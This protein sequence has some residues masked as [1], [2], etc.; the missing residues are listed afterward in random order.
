[1]MRSSLLTGGLVVALAT[2]LA[3]QAGPAPVRVFATGPGRFVTVD[4]LAG[5]LA[6]ADVAFIG[7]E[8]NDANSHRLELD[9]LEALARRRGEIVLSLEMFDRDVQEPLLHYAMGHIDEADFLA[10]ARPW[11]QYARA[12]KPIVDFAIAKQWPIVAANVPRSIAATVAKAG[13]IALKA[14]PEPD[15]ALFAKDLKCD[16]EGPYFRRFADAM[17]GHGDPDEPLVTDSSVDR[18][19]A[20]QCLKDETMAESIAQAYVAGAVDGKRPLVVSLN[21]AF[22]VEFEQGTVARTRR[23]LPDKSFV[24]IT[25]L[26]VPDLQAVSPDA[27]AK[28]R[29][30]FLVY[31][32]GT[33]TK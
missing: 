19:Y 13:L 24:V 30:D 14:Q 25:I 21:G 26:P 28:A 7:E 18:Y 27:V 10:Q 1:M 2:V 23:R 20:A 8:H 17:A 29:A 15:K 31:T 5:S 12:Y 16:P 6:R 22:H 32:V 4:D 33:R 9:L 3:G 11:P